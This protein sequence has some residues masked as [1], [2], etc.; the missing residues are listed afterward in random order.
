M[1]E[2]KDK[3]MDFKI[4]Y[5]RKGMGVAKT[6]LNRQEEYSFGLLLAARDN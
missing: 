6:I 5:G 4:H 2:E 1:V 3:K